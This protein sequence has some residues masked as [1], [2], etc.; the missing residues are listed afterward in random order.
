[1]RPAILAAALLLGGVVPPA[2]AQQAGRYDVQGEGANGAPYR[3][4]ASLAPIGAGT[5]RVEWQVEG[6]VARGIG[7]VIPEARMLVVAYTI[8]DEIGAVAYTIGADGVLRGRYTQGQAGFIAA[9]TLTPAGAS[10][11]K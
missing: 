5:W 8:Q 4:T 2:A 10:P 6:V 11:R 1:M 9:D 7:F 3:G